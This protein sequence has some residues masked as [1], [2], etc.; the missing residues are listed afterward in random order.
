[1]AK[2]KP[3]KKKLRKIADNLWR[4]IVLTQWDATCAYCGRTANPQA[5]HL[6]TRSRVAT[7]HEPMNGIVLCP[8]HHIF[9]TELSA[10][11]APLAFGDWLEKNH[12]NVR[13]WVRDHQQDMVKSTVGHY[14]DTIV[15][16]TAELEG[17]DE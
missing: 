14:E 5:H 16:L 2:R 7:R 17:E 13:Q 6:I 12:P 11:G 1:V 15:E 8:L 3:S 4:L 9:S 10:H